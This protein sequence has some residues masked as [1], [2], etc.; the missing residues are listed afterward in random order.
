MDLGTLFGLI[1]GLGLIGASMWLGGGVTIYA[2]PS[3]AL[4]VLGG[5]IAVAFVTHRAEDVLRAFGVAA[6]A[7]IH[8]PVPLHSLVPLVVDLAQQARKEGLVSLEGRAVPDPF[9][10]RG[11][12]MCIDGI[13]ADLVRD[14]LQRD[15]ASIR[16]RHQR[17]Q[18][19]FR[20]LAST[21]PAM[22]M[23][24]TLL[25]LVVMLRNMDDPSKIG[26]GMAVAILT[27][28]YGALLAYMVF[29]PIAD[30]LE[31]RTREEVLRKSM[32]IAAIE[33][34]VQAENRLVI[35]SRLGAFLAPRER[36]EAGR[37]RCAIRFSRESTSRP[38]AKA[39]RRG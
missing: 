15:L 4:I 1:A 28:L 12:R 19:V 26:P 25:G 27:T 31:D 6:Q 11:L 30:K 10:Q 34:I 33:S 21:A 5:T 18:R 37:R 24:G 2:D 20:L 14:S 17:G 3:S 13:S 22:G 9:L 23:I 35:Q 36:D 16:E 7:F 8:R 39:P 29:Q 38:R 32:L